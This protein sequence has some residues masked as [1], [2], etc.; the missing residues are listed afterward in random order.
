MLACPAGNGTDDGTD[1]N[2]R[3][4]RQKTLAMQEQPTEAVHYVD[5][6]RGAAFALR[7]F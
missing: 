1:E 2:D 4:H 3:K 7:P 6:R 5:H